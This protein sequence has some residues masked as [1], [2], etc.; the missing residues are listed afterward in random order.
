MQHEADSNSAAR[1][2]TC[3]HA[4]VENT[5]V[6]RCSQPALEH[7]TEWHA[8]AR[9][10]SP[11]EIVLDFGAGLT[12]LL[13]AQ[14]VGAQGRVIVVAK[15]NPLAAAG[16]SGSANVEFRHGRLPDLQLDL[17]LLEAWLQV[18]PART[19]DDWLRT[20]AHATQLRHTAPLI[21][22]DSIDVVLAHRT[23]NLVPRT[24]RQRA[25]TEIF[26]VLKRGGRVVIN[27]VVSDEI[28]PDTLPSDSHQY[29]GA[30]REDIVLEALE[31]AGFHGIEIIERQAEPHNTVAGIEFRAVTIQAFKGKAGPCFE[32]HQAVIYNGPWKAVI[33][34]DGHTLYRGKRMAV[35]DKTFQIYSRA[36]Y[37]DALTPV[38]PAKEIP[39]AQ[40]RPFNCKVNAIRDPRETKG[41]AAPG[42]PLLQISGDCGPEGCC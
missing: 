29:R 22:S 9:F 35:C 41:T 6:N 30:D 12:S 18:H 16:K 11:G 2:L 19:S 5:L 42:M 7:D 26:R 24:D 36:P 20:E 25:F 4:D 37:A 38:P 13:A 1:D 15:N 3:C 8:L 33:D 40:A 34:D 27:E 32:R 39:L 14:I 23:L 31:A 10:M 21:A 28:V 17:D